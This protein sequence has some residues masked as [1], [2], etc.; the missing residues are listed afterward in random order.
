MADEVRWLETVGAGD[1]EEVGG[2]NASL[3]EMIANLTGQ[4]IRVPGGFATTAAAFR[5]FVEA[6][7]LDAEI[8]GILGELAD[9]RRELADAGQAVRDLF[10]AAEFP[11]ATADAIRAAYEELG[12]RYDTTDVDVA[13]RSSATAEDLPEASF[14]GQQ[15]TYLNV[16]GAD[17]LLA[18]CKDCYASLFTDRAISYRVE[19]GFDHDEVALSIGVQKMVRSDLASAGV[20]FTIDT[21]TGFPDTAIINGAWG[22]GENVVG[23]EVTPDQWTVYKPFLDSEGLVPILARTVGAKERKRVYTDSGDAPTVN[24]DTTEE[25]R[26]T[27]VLT[28][29]EVLHLARWGA[30]IERHYDRPMDVEWAKDGR[31][32]ELF[33]VQ[34]RP[35]TV[36]SRAG[37]GTLSTFSLDETGE[38]LVSGL[39][40]GQAVA[41]G[42][43]QMISSAEDADRFSD[44]K[45]LVTSMTDPDWVPIMKRA[46]GIVTDRGGRTSHAAIVSRELGVPAVVGTQDATEV[47][48]DG[49]EVTLSCVEGDEG[50]VYDGIL[51][52]SERELDLEAVPQTRTRVM[53]N[54]GSPAAAMQWWRL[55][56]H[57]IGLARMEYLVNNVIQAHPLALLHLD[58]VSDPDARR[59]IEELTAGWEDK[60]EYFVDHLAHGIATIAASQYPEPV[61]V[62]LS[63]FKTNEYA[64]LIG[65]TQ[66]EPDE[67]NPMLGWRGASRY[68]SDDYR[69][70]FALECRA[71]ERVRTT[72]GFTNVVVMVPFCRTPEEADRVLETMAQYGLERGRDD[73]QVYV[74][75][76]IP[77]N[78]LQADEFAD[79]FDGFS[80]GS[81]DLTQ[82]TLG[83]GRDDDRLTHLFDERN[84][85]VKKMI[86]MLIEAAHAK[87]RYVG[88][89]GQGPSDHPDLAEF[90]VEAGI[91]SMSL[92]PDSVLTVVER[93]AEAES[94]TT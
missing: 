38:L 70:A 74:M 63:D 36:Q 58:E 79:R 39:A 13:V 76:E 9:G 54:I 11:Q 12:K 7:G 64:G 31:T 90:L 86:T 71:L 6:N 81:N 50:H 43:V 40:I 28:D 26:R 57:G 59:Q 29:D 14:A 47:L 32:G 68:D 78:I 17:A 75:A 65:G 51:A 15:D 87:G 56:A 67:E 61:V 93:V 89:C 34:A 8:R 27:L 53:M 80:I 48:A 42:E 73:L 55:P 16:V 22:L 20:M 30:V 62:R 66:F 91:D 23:G 41:A 24:V 83:I 52:F 84:P 3:G 18:A 88:I 37:A 2:K 72:M 21:D 45:V 85:A 82:L 10:D 69:E 49:R 94:R 33:V 44:G 77:S 35:E 46:A 5:S 92:N 4:G 25:E 60:G 19:Q 1:V